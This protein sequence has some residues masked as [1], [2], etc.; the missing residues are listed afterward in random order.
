[1]YNLPLC[2]TCVFYETNSGNIDKFTAH[3]CRSPKHVWTD[4]DTKEWGGEHPLP[5]PFT[6]KDSMP[7]FVIARHCDYTKGHGVGMETGK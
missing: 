3:C 5:S 4:E 2:K 1:M 6:L 7:P